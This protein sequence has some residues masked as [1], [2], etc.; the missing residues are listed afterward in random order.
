MSTNKNPF[1]IRTDLLS[2]AK[3]YMDRQQTIAEEFAKQA[4]KTAIESGKANAEMLE[5]FKP[6]MYSIEDLKAV[7]E[8]MYS[9]VA[10]VTS[11]PQTLN[12]GKKK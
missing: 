12:E 10:P 7:A 2:M 11:S 5:K 9:F 8:Q 1:E 6:A 4:Y 3:D